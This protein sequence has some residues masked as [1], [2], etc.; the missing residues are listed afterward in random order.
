MIETVNNGDDD[1]DQESRLILISVLMS[2]LSCSCSSALGRSSMH[3][4]HSLA[5]H[6]CEA[7]SGGQAPDMHTYD[8]RALAK[9]PVDDCSPQRLS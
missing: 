5:L 3:S 7:S 4:R 8:V 1:D 9:E 6:L 2:S